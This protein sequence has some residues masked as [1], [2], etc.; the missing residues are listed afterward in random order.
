ML[1]SGE[2][3]DNDKVTWIYDHT[4][5]QWTQGPILNRGRYRFGCAK[6]K[7]PAHENREVLIVAGGYADSDGYPF[8]SVEILDYTMTD[9]WETGPK[10]PE[11]MVEISLVTNQNGNGVLV[12][13]QEKIH[14]LKCSEQGC[15]WVKLEQELSVGRDDYVAMLIPDEL[16]NCQ[17]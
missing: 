3:Y 1:I 8:D 12:V 7:S 16:V 10:L 13:Y 15:E 11:K 14:E 6:F 2:A 5:E 4:N 17:K 9:E